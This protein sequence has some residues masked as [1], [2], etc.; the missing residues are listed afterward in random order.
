M[1]I[2]DSKKVFFV[3]GGTNC[4]PERFLHEAINRKNKT[5]ESSKC[6][7]IQCL[8]VIPLCVGKDDEN[9]RFDFKK[10]KENT[11]T[12]GLVVDAFNSW[13]QFP[14]KLLQIANNKS[15]TIKENGI[16]IFVGGGNVVKDEIKLAI[17]GNR[18]EEIRTNTYMVI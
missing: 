16:G 1:D 7:N 15:I 11:I 17:S 10:I 13:G 5:S 9:A 14:L 12:H 2:V 6:K 18:T 3:T 8:G 4:G